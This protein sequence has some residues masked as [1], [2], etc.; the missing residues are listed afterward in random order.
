MNIADKTVAQFHYIL[1]DEAG[2]EIE[3]SHGH[4]PLAYLHGANNTL[5]GLEKALTDKATGDK[6]TVTLQPEEAY[7]ERNETLV[8]R[9]SAKHLH[10]LPSK[11]AKWQPGMIAIVQTEQGQRQV[12]VVKT[13]KFM[14]T[15]DI[16]PPLAGKVLTFDIEVLDVRAA[17]EEE[18][19][20]GHVHNGSCGHDH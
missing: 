4:E 8:E 14:V 20:H 7:G 17:T 3:S 1:K 19:Q 18:I 2:N 16:N 15:V 6:F 13:G 11:N 10:G 12:T 9:V 5:P